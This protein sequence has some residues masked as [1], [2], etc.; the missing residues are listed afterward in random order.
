MQRYFRLFGFWE[1]YK[2]TGKVETNTKRPDFLVRQSFNMLRRNSDCEVILGLDDNHPYNYAMTSLNGKCACKIVDNF[3]DTVAELKRKEAR[4]GVVF[5]EDVLSME[6]KPCVDLS[7]V[8][9]LLVVY[10]LINSLM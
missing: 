7:L 10:G 6:V 3:G 9:G 1:G 5:G 2:S 8:M 4:S